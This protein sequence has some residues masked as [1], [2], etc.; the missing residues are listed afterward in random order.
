MNRHPTLTVYQ[1]WMPKF[2][3]YPNM[4]KCDL[5]PIPTKWKLATL[6]LEFWI[7]EVP[8][9]PPPP[10][11]FFSQ[12]LTLAFGFAKCVHLM[13]RRD[14][15]CITHYLVQNVDQTVCTK[16]RNC[17]SA[18]FEKMLFTTEDPSDRLI[19]LY[20]FADHF[21]GFLALEVEKDSVLEKYWP[22]TGFFSSLPASCKGSS[23]FHL[24]EKPLRCTILERT[25]LELLCKSTNIRSSLS[26]VHKDNIKV[27]W[28][29]LKC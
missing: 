21:V 1:K 17:I 26:L 16:T 7:F 27:P 19:D 3:G 9:C 10:P 20:F 23:F 11:P 22:R 6:Q 29:N 15:K 28:M 25:V 24:E 12:E 4:Q 5:I 2:A 13:S 18:N 14:L 8:L